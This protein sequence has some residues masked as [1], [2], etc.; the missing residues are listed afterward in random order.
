MN[1]L[2]Y[3]LGIAYYWVSMVL[4]ILYI[5][6][7]A[8]E[9]S[10]QIKAYN[11][12]MELVRNGT[13]NGY[14]VLGKMGAIDHSRSFMLRV[15]LIFIIAYNEFGICLKTFIWMFWASMLYWFIFTI[16]LNK[17]LNKAWFFVGTTAKTDRF[18]QRLAVI[19]GID[20]EKLMAGMMGI[21]LCIASLINMIF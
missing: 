11:K 16:V 13:L 1:L 2:G 5:L 6:V 18:I 19:W 4:L 8:W 17:L 12:A 14:N 3:N 21:L 7:D 15:I 10:N 20:P 9:D